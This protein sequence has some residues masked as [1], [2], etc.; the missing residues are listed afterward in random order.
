MKML[1]CPIHVPGRG[2]L[3]ALLLMTGAAVPMLA[4]GAESAVATSPLAVVNGTVIE[5]SA[6]ERLVR[7]EVAGGR[8]DSPELREA[9]LNEL[10]NQEVLA[11]EAI[12]R[13]LDS[14]PAFLAAIESAK[15]QALAQL[16]LGT[17]TP[18]PIDEAAVRA[19]Y[20]RSLTNWNPKDVRLRAIVADQ[21]ETIRSLRSR[22]ARGGDFAELAAQHRNGVIRD[23]SGDLG[24]QNIKTAGERPSNVLPKPVA[25]AV[26]E[27]PRGGISQP[28]ADAEGRWW[29]VKIE[30]IRDSNPASFEAINGQLRAAL[31]T[32]S[33]NQAAVALLQSLRADANIQR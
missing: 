9:L 10:I 4:M 18:E 26:R 22:L 8:A 24:W 19:L 13:G 16:M 28:I 11:Q 5:A 25:E 12:R 2:L 1:R 27:L 31:E 23:P 14:G 33:R 7:R 32:A 3:A 17:A 20:D 15:R 29:L 30:D 6:V 21:E